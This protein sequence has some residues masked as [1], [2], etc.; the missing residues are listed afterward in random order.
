[1]TSPIRGNRIIMFLL[2]YLIITGTIASSL[3]GMG[4]LDP[5]AGIIVHQI[6]SFGI[7]FVIYML[8][9]KHKISDVI[10]IKPLGIKNII[11][12][13]AII[14]VATPMVGF[15]SLLSSLFVEN[16][17]P[18]V[19]DNVAEFHL[20][21]IILAIGVAPSI[22]E[23]IMF[24]GVIYHEYKNIPIRK[25]AFVNGIFFGIMH[26]NFHQFI[27][28]FALGVLFCYFLYYTKS[29]LAPII[30]HFFINGPQV[31]INYFIPGVLADTPQY[32]EEIPPMEMFMVIIFLGAIAVALLP[33][34][35]FLI[36]SFA[37][38][39]K[40]KVGVVPLPNIEEEGAH[41]EENREG[42]ITWEFWACVVFFIMVASTF[43]FI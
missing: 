8:V 26:L 29:I 43:I 18:Q 11:Y 40:D 33:L 27:Y 16:P 24:R 1:M 42:V 19:M 23:E 5:I 7:P 30:A 25:A 34:I 14:A 32:Y 28:A 35:I 13:A 22:F 4:I 17:V 37:Q 21:M 39:N 2:P 38:H 12:I 36:R 9:T 20:W 6:I 10:P 41:S 3:I 15:V 31:I